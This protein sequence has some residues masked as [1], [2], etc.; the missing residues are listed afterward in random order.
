MNAT[1][2]APAPATSTPAMSTSDWNGMS[3]REKF[4]ESM[5]KTDN[6][7]RLAQYAEN[8]MAL[9]KARIRS[10]FKVED[11]RIADSS[12]DRGLGLIGKSRT[13]SAQSVEQSFGPVSGASFKAM[14]LRA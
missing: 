4:G 10:R 3:F 6:Q 5:F 12:D 9:T 14:A 7:R 2:T 8:D 13:V 11:A 1:T